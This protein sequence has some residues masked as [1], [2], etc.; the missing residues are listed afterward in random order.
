MENCTLRVKRRTRDIHI[1]GMDAVWTSD[2]R[3]WDLTANLFLGSLYFF[4]V[5]AIFIGA[6]G[7]GERNC[8]NVSLFNFK[9]K[10]NVNTR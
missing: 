8:S 3:S 5:S 10:Y 6:L 9:Q 4:M 2:R 7:E 1:E